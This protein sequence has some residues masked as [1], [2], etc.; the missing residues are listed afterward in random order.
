[1]TPFCVMEIGLLVV[2][3]L[4]VTLFEIRYHSQ[5]V[6][7]LATSRVGRRSFNVV[8]ISSIIV[9]QGYLLSIW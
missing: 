3:L 6:D 2:I 7:R 1:M 9:A 5:M 4:V 8:I